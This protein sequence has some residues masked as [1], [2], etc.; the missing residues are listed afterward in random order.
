MNENLLMEGNTEVLD[1]VKTFSNFEIMVLG[2]KTGNIGLNFF[3]V[4]IREM[5]D[6][7]QGVSKFWR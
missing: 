6:T 3:K 2:D 5:T 4:I 7:K 1:V